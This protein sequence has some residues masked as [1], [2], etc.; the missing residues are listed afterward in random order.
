MA[1]IVESIVG[2]SDRVYRPTKLA[3]VVDTLVRDGV[4]I[5]EVLLDLGVTPDEL[6]SPSTLV[7]LEQLLAACRSA[8]RLSRDPSLPFRIG[9]SIHVST[10][11]M[12]GYAILCGTDFRKT[13]HFCVRYHVLATPLVGI[14]FVERD[15]MAVWKIDPILHRLVDERLY[16]FIVEMQIGVHLSLQR[17]VMGSSFAPREIALTYSRSADFWLT[18]ELVGCKVRFSQPANQFIF[19][20]KWVDNPASLGNRTTY[21]A[22]VAMCEELLAD[23]QLRTGVAGKVRASLLQDMANRP[24]FA[25]IA[26]RLGATTRTLRRQLDHQ[27]T[28]FR[29]LV[30]ELR[31][32]VAVKYLRDTVMTNDDI[33]V[34]LGFSD[35]ANFRHAFR[36]WTGRTPREFRGGA[37]LSLRSATGHRPSY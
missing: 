34:A 17:D 35:A 28:S 21:A 32:Q 26:K 7:S 16:R 18:E 1:H 6:H 27:G 11:G 15:G 8:I 30:D 36:R 12:Y 31:A 22:V 9:S 3:A 20:A 24:T 2:V 37:R 33:A 13:F 14:S 4:S 10:Y 25:A 29:E 23:L 5:H 19:D